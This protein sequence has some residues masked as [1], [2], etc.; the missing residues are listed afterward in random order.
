MSSKTSSS[1]V[2][3]VRVMTVYVLLHSDLTNQNL[4]QV[5]SSRQKCKAAEASG[6]SLKLIFREEQENVDPKLMDGVDPVADLSD[7]KIESGSEDSI[8]MMD[9][10]D[11]DFE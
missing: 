5:F 8:S 1:I 3:Q 10:D 6:K 4:V 2:T 9:S 7:F 11:S